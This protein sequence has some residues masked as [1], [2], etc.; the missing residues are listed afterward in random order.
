MLSAMSIKRIV[1]SP[2][3]TDTPSP[4]RVVST[5]EG[6]DLWSQLYD[7]EENPLI[8]LEERHRGR[9]L[10]D[11]AGLSVLDVGC[12]TGRQSLW[13]AHQGARVTALDFS[14]GMLSKAQNKPGSE[15]VTFIRHDLTQPFPVVPGSF[16]RVVSCLVLDHIP[17]PT[18]FLLQLARACKP[19][20][21]VFVSVMHPAMMLKGVQARFTDPG[22]GVKTYPASAANSVS[23]YVM[24]LV[25]TG[26]PL[27]EFSEFAVD[28]AMAATNPRA[29]KYLDWPM[30]LLMVLERP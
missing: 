1:D 29:A 24:A 17:D 25:R 2:K 10:G 4:E 5:M 8:E 16:D 15:H 19:G 30:L 11:L 6:Y 12:G 18:A 21:R 9:I 7:E 20:G 26:L 27:V 22:T 3:T 14:E 23:T 13:M 28:A